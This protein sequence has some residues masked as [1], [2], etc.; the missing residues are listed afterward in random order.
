MQTDIVHGINARGHLDRSPKERIVLR[1]AHGLPDGWVYWVRDICSLSFLLQDCVVLP[2]LVPQPLGGWSNKLQILRGSSS[3]WDHKVDFVTMGWPST[4]MM[5]R[6]HSVTP[7]A[8]ACTGSLRCKKYVPS[9][10]TR[11]PWW[12]DQTEKYLIQIAIANLKDFIP[13]STVKVEMQ[14]SKDTKVKILFLLKHSCGPSQS[15]WELNLEWLMMFNDRVQPHF[16]MCLFQIYILNY[17]ACHIPLKCRYA[18]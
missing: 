9:N 2:T 6:G 17:E 3:Y 13:S 5:W 4:I 1:V 18:S 16:N 10:F 12:L 7:H 15:C 14:K 11:K 8:K